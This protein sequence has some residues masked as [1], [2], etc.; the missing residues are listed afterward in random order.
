MGTDP[1]T[2]PVDPEGLF[3]GLDN[4]YVTDASV[5]STSAAVNP[6][7]T[8]AAS[9]LRIGAGIAARAFAGKRTGALLEAPS[10][11]TV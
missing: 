11:R 2:A 7:L 3:R 5:F 9:A 6:S 4:L 8:I 1:R 10:S